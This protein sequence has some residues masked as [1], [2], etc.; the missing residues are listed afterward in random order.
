MTLAEKLT[1]VANNRPKL[2]KKGYLDASPQE[3]LSGEA[4]GIKDIS[5]IEHNMTIKVSGIEDI[6]TVKLYKQGKNW[7]NEKAITKKTEKTIEVDGVS[8]DVYDVNGYTGDYL[9]TTNSSFQFDVYMKKGKDYTVSL[10]WMG[11]SDEKNQAGSLYMPFKDVKGGNQCFDNM[12]A[13][14][15]VLNAFGVSGISKTPLTKITFRISPTE[16]I[17][18]GALCYYSYGVKGYVLKDSIQIEEGTSTE[19]EPYIEPTIYDVQ[20]DG[21]VEGVTSLY[22]NTTL[23]TDTQGAVIDCTYYQDGKK[24]K[25]NLTDIILSLGGVINE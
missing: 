18:K 1:E 14:N 11:S 6:S 25:E 8:Y 2:Y 3:T 17:V 23:Y 4:I 10:I 5:P 24:V 15:A 12:G 20:A 9:Y 16:D 21:I 13:G 7:F 22:P 19:Y